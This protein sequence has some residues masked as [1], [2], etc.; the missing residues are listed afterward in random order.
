[1][2]GLVLFL[3]SYAGIYAAMLMPLVLSPVLV[4]SS[5][6]FLQV[7]RDNSKADFTNTMRLNILSSL[8]INL[9]FLIFIF[10]GFNE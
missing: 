8:C 10:F 6:W 7:L 3:W 5:F 4:Y 2:T 9:Y 1:M